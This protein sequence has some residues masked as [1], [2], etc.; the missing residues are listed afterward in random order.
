M[1]CH[2]SRRPRAATWSAGWCQRTTTRFASTCRHP[3]A[4]CLPATWRRCWH[5]D[6]GALFQHDFHEAGK[7]KRRSTS[8]RSS[9][10]TGRTSRFGRCPW[11]AV[12][13]PMTQHPGVLRSTDRLT[14]ASPPRLAVGLEQLKARARRGSRRLP[15][16]GTR[17]P[18]TKIA[19]SMRGR[20]TS[21]RNCALSCL[22][23]RAC[24]WLSPPGT[25]GGIIG[26]WGG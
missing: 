24:W 21:K 20:S 16:M 4:R 18:E 25:L 15:G 2:A 11:R 14:Q 3:I 23:V 6:I 5:R 12:E 8:N 7:H 10:R 22:P 9:T 13:I 19:P 1:C 26:P 17:R